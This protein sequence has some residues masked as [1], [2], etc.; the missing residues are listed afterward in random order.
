MYDK[1]ETGKVIIAVNEKISF[2]EIEFYISIAL[3]NI[4]YEK[5]EIIFSSSMVMAKNDAEN[6]ILIYLKD[7]NPT[8]VIKAIEKLSLSPYINYAEPDYLEE[9]HLVSN[10]P[11][12]NY[13]WG[14][15]KV[16][17]FGME[18]YNWK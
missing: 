12:Y 13:L 17:A 2:D 5:I 18:L 4:E 10:D 7:K 15:Q 9:M 11:L 3:E 16:N 14:I 6:I 1:Y 8:T